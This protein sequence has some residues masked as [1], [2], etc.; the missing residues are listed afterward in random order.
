MSLLA[1]LRYNQWQE[2]NR[3]LAL[4]YYFSLTVEHS[5]TD[6]FKLGVYH[7]HFFN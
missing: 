4:A 5:E 2:R 1:L 6:V 7:I 3:S